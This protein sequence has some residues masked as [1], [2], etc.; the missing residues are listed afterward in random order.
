MNLPSVSFLPVLWNIVFSQRDKRYHN[1]F[2]G[3]FTLNLFTAVS[4]VYPNEKAACMNIFGY[5][6]I[7]LFHPES[8]KEVLKSN[9]L[10]NKDS[11]YDF[12][13]PLL[14]DNNILYS[15][16]DN[17][18]R[19]RKYLAP[20]YHLW[21][22]KNNQNILM[23]HSNVLVEKLKQLQ[24][25]EIFDILE[26][27]KY[28]T[29]DIIADIAVGVSLHSQTTNDQ[30][31]ASAMHRILKYFPQWL[32][33]PMY[34]FFPIFFMSKIG[35]NYKRDVEIIHRF[36]EK[37]FKGKKENFVKKMQQQPSLNKETHN[38][39]KPKI[40]TKQR[41]IDA[42]LDLHVKQGLISEEDVIGDMEG[43]IFGGHDSTSHALSWTFYFL[44]RFHEIQE[45]LY[46]EL[47]EIF[48]NDMKRDITIDDLTKMTYLECV[49]KES[50]R[51]YPPF[52]FI[53]RKNPTEMKISNYVLPANA[54]LVINIYGI[55][56][57][58]SVYENPEVFDPDRFL[59]E[60]YKNLH[61]YAF[62]GF[63]AGPRNCIGSKLAM[64]KM[65]MVL[66][67]VL[68]NFKVYSLDPQDKIVTSWD[69]ML[70]PISGIRM[71]VEQRRML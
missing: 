5:K 45:K 66:A 55:H 28:C 11:T 37:L 52:P 48:K 19:R 20:H 57:N 18:R 13:K 36:D 21:N 10:I 27:M 24:K 69:V 49:I 35:K 50:I 41:I 9:S 59:P 61:P 38:E 34:W 6:F 2:I 22:L 53:A 16:D 47:Q 62:L 51:I 68:R 70:T 31:Y 8:A 58:P 26:W 64:I 42:L 25:N 65:K 39:E 33:N 32:F 30:E 3:I 17:W 46:L 54:T 56:H 40:K 23:K 67:N 71:F 14:G 7:C 29:L 15:S 1:S 63:S 12:L 44:G 4:T 43:V 60:N